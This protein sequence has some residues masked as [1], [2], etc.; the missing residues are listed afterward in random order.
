MLSES[1]YT[2]SWP[3]FSGITEENSGLLSDVVYDIDFDDESGEIYFATELGI[4]ILKSPFGQISYSDNDKYE[5]YF[6]KNPFLI[7]KDERVVI[8]NVPMGSTLKIMTLDG[9]ILRTINK[10]GFTMYQW[11][12]K[13]ESGNYVRSG[14][15]IVA[16]INSEE[17]TAIGKLAIVRE[18]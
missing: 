12:G 11:D 15:Y 8:S 9:K 6:D 16:S 7:P 3:S 10:D 14:V 2:E 18:K 13:D 5:I 17:K 1:N 4:S